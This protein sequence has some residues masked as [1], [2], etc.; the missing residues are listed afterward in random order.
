MSTRRCCTLLLLLFVLTSLAIA[1]KS[2]PMSVQMS[3]GDIRSIPEFFGSVVDTVKYADLVTVDETKG[4]WV[5]VVSPSGKTGWIHS[6]A[7]TADKLKAEAGDTDVASSV[8]AG[9]MATSTKGFCPEAEAG[10]KKNNPNLSFDAVDRMEKVKI[11]IEQ[12]Q[13]FLKQGQVEGPKGG[14]K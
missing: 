13:A 12:I 5:K 9:E 11:S 10:F 7:L 2:K 3:K 6:S 1:A 4:S 14:A 8:S